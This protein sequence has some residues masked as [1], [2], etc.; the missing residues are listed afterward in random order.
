MRPGKGEIG[1]R[2]GL[3]DFQGAG[4]KT[5]Y[6]PRL[7]QPAISKAT[8]RGARPVGEGKHCIEAEK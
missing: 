3:I 7:N 2:G 5:V 1:P 6:L 4:E 8:K